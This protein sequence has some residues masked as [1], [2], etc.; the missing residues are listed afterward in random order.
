MSCG[1]KLNFTIEEQNLCFN[2]E[3]SNLAFNADLGYIR[4]PGAYPPLSEKPQVNDHT[5]I[6]NKSFEDLGLKSMSNIEIKAIFDKVFK[7]GN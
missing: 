6:G 1:C 2:L 4:N 3:K 7:G 5:L